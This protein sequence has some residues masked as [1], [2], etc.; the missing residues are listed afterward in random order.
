M[1]TPI[2]LTIEHLEG[3]PHGKPVR[4]TPHDMKMIRLGIEYCTSF[5][6]L[7]K[8]KEKETIEKAFLAGYLSDNVN[9]PTTGEDFFNKQ[10]GNE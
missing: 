2:E 9:G 1:K 5:L 6:N 10:F 4:R 8:E 3:W 7:M